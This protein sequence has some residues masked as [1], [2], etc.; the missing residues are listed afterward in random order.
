METIS[1]AKTSLFSLPLDNLRE[2]LVANNFKRFAGEQIYSWLYAKGEYDPTKWTNISKKLQEHLRDEM[3]MSLPKVVWAAQAK[4]GTRKF[5]LRLSDGKT[6]ESVLIYATDRLTQCISS[7]VGCAIGCTFCHTASQGF[8]RHL[9]VEEVVGQYYAIARWLRE[10]VGE[11]E[12]I[13][14]LVYMGQGEPL[15]NFENIKLATEIFLEDKGPDFGQRK[16]TLSTS[17]L[18]PQ[19]EKLGDFPP[20]NIAISLHAEYIH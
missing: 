9:K 10:N 20:V 19:I 18:V 15:H 7:Q 2:Y 12:K 11:G 13:T 16:I 8:E 17:G 3:D 6:V 5:L 1:D 4:D 14:N